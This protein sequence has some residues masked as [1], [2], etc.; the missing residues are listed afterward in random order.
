MSGH[1]KP[2]LKFILLLP[3]PYLVFPNGCHSFIQQIFIEYI[4]PLETI[5]ETILVVNQTNLYGMNILMRKVGYEKDK[6]G[7]QIHI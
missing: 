6:D 5:P 7:K 3:F 2:V 4:L 1:P